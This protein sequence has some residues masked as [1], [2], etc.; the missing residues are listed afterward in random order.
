[1]QV[2]NDEFL[3]HVR[4]GRC[5]YVRGDTLRLTPTGVRVKIREQVEKGSALGFGG[6]V[7]KPDL[8]DVSE[9]AR[10]EHATEENNKGKEKAQDEPRVEDIKADVV[11]LATGYKRPDISFLPRELFP[12][13]YDASS[14]CSSLRMLLTGMLSEAESVS[15]KLLHRR[16]VRFDDEFVVSQCY[17]HSWPFVRA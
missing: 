6:G 16:L 17:R 15:A 14:C 4:S 13:G 9:V 7:R 3:N 2:V 5:V 10:E 11:I 12:E 1:M 8:Q